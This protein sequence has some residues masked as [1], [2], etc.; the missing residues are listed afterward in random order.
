MLEYWNIGL[1]SHDFCVEIQGFR[2]NFHHFTVDV[3]VW[4]GD[5]HP[6][7]AMMALPHERLPF[8]DAEDPLEAQNP[9]SGPP[10][11]R[12]EPTA[13]REYAMRDHKID[14]DRYG[15]PKPRYGRP[16]PCAHFQK[17]PL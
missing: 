5:D 6:L 3:H 12:G 17:Q 9:A 2:V 7:M 10:A 4:A 8:F 16:I 13:R 15:N 1:K 14:I 11:R